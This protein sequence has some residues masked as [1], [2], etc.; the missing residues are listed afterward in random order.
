[1]GGYEEEGINPLNL[2]TMVQLGSPGLIL[3]VPQQ[4]GGFPK[5]GFL[6]GAHSKDYSILGCILGPPVLGN[7]HVPEA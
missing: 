4:H 1:M 3:S 6:G 2:N 7:Y 5:F